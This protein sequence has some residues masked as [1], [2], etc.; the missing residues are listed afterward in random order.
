MSTPRKR[1]AL[2]AGFA[3]LAV[4][5]PLGATAYAEA[6]TANA[7]ATSAASHDDREL[8]QVAYFIQWGIYGRSFSSRTSTRPGRP[9]A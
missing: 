7:G 2:I 3:A 6:G 5:A 8:R 9:P 4:V 1:L